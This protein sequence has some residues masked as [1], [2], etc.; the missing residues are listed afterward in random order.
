MYIIFLEKIKEKGIEESLKNNQSQ[1][2]HHQL[3][4]E[5]LDHSPVIQGQ[6]FPPLHVYD[7]PYH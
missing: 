2:P 6:E 7:E 5:G 3:E 4:I 1:W